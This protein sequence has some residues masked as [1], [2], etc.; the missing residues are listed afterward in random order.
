[1]DRLESYGFVA[2]SVNGCPCQLCSC[3]PMVSSPFS[4]SSILPLIHSFLS[5]FLE[6]R[7]AVWKKRSTGWRPMQPL[8]LSPHCP[9]EYSNSS[10]SVPFYH[11]T[12]KVKCLSKQPFSKYRLQART[13]R[14]NVVRM[15]SVAKVRPIPARC[16][17][18][19]LISL[20]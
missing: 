7:R 4:P 2:L 3:L 5:S 9:W 15:D 17:S 20:E 14:T 13:E 19:Y 6:S 8:P 11:K 1:M 16:L 18:A 12:R 10:N